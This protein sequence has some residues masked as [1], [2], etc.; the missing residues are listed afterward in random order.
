[1]S[2]EHDEIEALEDDLE[3]ASAT[4]VELRALL[5][6]IRDAI[7]APGSHATK[8]LGVQVALKLAGEL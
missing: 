2:F 4:I 6:E 7:N 3:M 1:M 8:L 5:D